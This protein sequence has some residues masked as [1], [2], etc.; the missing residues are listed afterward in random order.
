L[1]EKARFLLKMGVLVGKPERDHL[2]DLG[3][4]RRKI[5]K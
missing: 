1:G 5:I 2:K 4:Y 3:I